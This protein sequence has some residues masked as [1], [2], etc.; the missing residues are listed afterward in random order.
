MTSNGNTR[1]WALDEDR[2]PEFG[3]LKPC[4]WGSDA[5]SFDRLFEPAEHR[6]CWIK[7]DP[8]F[9]GLMQILCE[10]ADR[11]AIQEDR[12]EPHNNHRSIE[13]VRFNDKR[14]QKEPVFFNE[15]LTCIIGGRSTGKSL[16]LRQVARSISLDYAIEQEERSSLSTLDGF[17]P[18]DVFWR[19][20]AQSGERKIIYLPQTHLNRTVDDPESGETGASAL[21]AGVLLQN[22]QIGDAHERFCESRKKVGLIFIV[23]RTPAP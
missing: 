16:L 12:P 1:D 4:I 19:D 10:P 13:S 9:E 20:G 17:K 7:A 2:I 11:I 8:T 5:H 18:V 14:F 23:S 22:E 15:G 6:Y 21:I 3:S